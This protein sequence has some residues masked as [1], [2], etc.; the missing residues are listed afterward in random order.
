[1]P[2]F[3]AFAAQIPYDSEL[4]GVFQPLFGWKGARSRQL[5]RLALIQR[6]ASVASA[7]AGPSAT[8]GNTMAVYA[9]SG[10]PIVDFLTQAVTAQFA[11]RSALSRDEWRGLLK[12]DLLA[13]AVRGGAGTPSVDPATGAGADLLGARYQATAQVIANLVDTQPEAL[14]L[15]LLSASAT[16]GSI[17]VLS[18]FPRL[19]DSVLCPLGILTLFR[20]YFFELDSFVGPPVGHVWL[21]PGATVELFE[22][23]VKRRLIEKAIESTLEITTKSELTTETKEELSESVKQENADDLKLAASASGGFNI[24]V[25]HGEGSASFNL[26]QT[27]KTA[28]EQTHKRSRNQTEKKSTEIRQSFKT[29][30]RTVSEQTDTT[31]KRYVLSNTTDKLINYELRRKMRRVAVQLQHIGTRLCWQYYVP[32]P[33]DGLRTSQLVHL[34]Q[35]SDADAGLTPPEKPPEADEK[36]AEFVAE[37]PLVQA[38]GQWLSNWDEDFDFGK[39]RGNPQ[40]TCRWEFPFQQHPPVGYELKFADFVQ[41]LPQGD[42]GGEPVLY[43]KVS[44]ELDNSV[45]EA[46]AKTNGMFVVKLPG[47]NWHS[48]KGIR[49]RLKLVYGPNDDTKK[50]A[51]QEYQKRQQNYDDQR[52]RA[53]KDAYVRAVRDRIKAAGEVKARPFEDLRDEERQSMY[54][55]LIDRLTHD[56]SATADKHVAAEIVAQLFDVDAMLYFVAPDWWDPAVR[57]QATLSAPQGLVNPMDQSVFTLQPSD[58][59][60]WGTHWSTSGPPYPVTEE[61][62]PAPLGA[63]LGWLLQLDGDPMRNAFLNAAWAK[64]VVP[65]RPGREQDAIAWLQSETEEDVGLKETYQLQPGD[66]QE[67]AGKT[68]R[69]VID[70]LITA[71][72]AEY[73][74]SMTVDSKFDALPGER[75]YEKGFDPLTGGVKFKAEPFAV[76]DQ[77]VEAL[78]TDQVV[79]VSYPTP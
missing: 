8:A 17:D 14:N 6:I 5:Q 59:V 42:F 41:K 62:R 65:I 71:I 7:V 37:L 18:R 67:W 53:Y 24:G 43:A 33:G 55:R 16:L 21:S 32:T 25:A 70:A 35:I 60:D 68:L 2:D 57:Q 54:R 48:A 20:E 1:M 50:N 9:A 77:W 61:S 3:S 27:R 49:A 76:F 78:P 69:D 19:A 31:S 46:E 66:P 51:E 44:V 64:V 11:G 40:K 79:A 34:A 58:R 10:N 74:S 56:G 38:S 28:S 47:I 26:D 23:T 22:S 52:S 45:K 13:S 12:P 39:A 15:L 63:S 4:L 29:T 36:T 30:F 73:T 75:V 72:Q